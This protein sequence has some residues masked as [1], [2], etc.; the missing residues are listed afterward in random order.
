MVRAEATDEP[1]KRGKPAAADHRGRGQAAAHL[2][3]HRIGRVI[4][5][6]AHP[7]PGDVAHEDEQA[8]PRPVPAKASVKVS[9]ANRPIAAFQRVSSQCRGNRPRN[10]AKATGTR[11]DQQ[12]EVPDPKR[13]GGP[14]AHASLPVA[15]VRPQRLR[16]A[17]RSS[18]P[19]RLSAETDQRPSGT[20]PWADSEVGRQVQASAEFERLPDSPDDKAKTTAPA[21]PTGYR[22]RFMRSADS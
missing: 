21:A 9:R 11:Q 22:A 19:E 14:N 4:Q 7:G 2:A 5:F 10:I 12:Q 13:T 20:R 18:M 8:A 15:D 1:D 16:S 3:D 17:A 6:A